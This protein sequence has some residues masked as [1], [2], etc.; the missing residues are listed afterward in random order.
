MSKTEMV[1]RST[2]EEIV[3]VY[4]RSEREIRQGCAL[5]FGAEKALTAAFSIGG[6]YGIDFRQEDCR[7]RL[8][9]DKPDLAIAYLRKQIWG[10]LVDRL[11]VRRLMSMKKAKELSA[12]LEKESGK[13]QITVDSVLG[14]FRY[15]VENLDDMLR[16]QVEEVFEL[17]RPRNSQLVTNSK[18]EI[19][20][21]VILHYWVTQR[22]RF[23]QGARVRY[24]R[25]SEYVALENVFLALDGRGSISKGYRTELERAIS[26]TGP[27]GETTY[28][29]YRACANGNLHLEFKR[30]D[31]LLKFNRMAGGKRLRP[32][33]EDSSPADVEQSRVA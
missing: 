22:S 14:F 30:K 24:D 6:T 19:G 7:S 25:S 20:P 15:Y 17:L 10:V 31:L 33:R 3:R 16:E 23:E 9:F 12:W 26:E 1:P 5:I 4:E 29:K 8:D 18:Y 28:F 2:V 21:K 27:E 32:G 11:E 13:E